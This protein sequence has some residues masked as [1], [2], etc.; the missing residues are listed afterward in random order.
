MERPYERLSP[1][2]IHV[3]RIKFDR[4]HSAI[5]QVRSRG[6]DPRDVR[7]I[8]VTH[9]DFDHA[10]GLEDFP[11]ARV[12]VLQAEAEAARARQGFI[13]RRRY[14]P[15]QWDEVRHWEFYRAGGERWFG[16]EAVRGLKGLPPEILMV[17]LPGHTPGHA[18]I[19]VDTPDGWL[20][21]AADAYFHRHEM[22]PE[23]RSTPGLAFYQQLME[24]DRDQRVH[25][26]ER[27]WELANDPRAG[28]RVFC[29]HDPVELEALSRLSTGMRP[30]GT[31]RPRSH[32]AR[33]PA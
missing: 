33:A 22:D 32:A 15:E 14:R 18:G 23:P 12:H 2:F 1:L 4:S 16:F 31:A 21:N 17:P 3:N 24:T 9:L 25:N 27:V 28:V 29:S 5:E 11:N 7:H 6:F 8:L 10:G 26:K 30:R 19:A 13:G 20:F